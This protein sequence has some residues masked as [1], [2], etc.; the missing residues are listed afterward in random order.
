M[1]ETKYETKNGTGSFTS[2]SGDASLLPD[3]I[4]ITISAGRSISSAVTTPWDAM[5]DDV[6]AT[7]FAELRY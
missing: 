2:R 5:G 7:V 6:M 1:G 4:L 3:D